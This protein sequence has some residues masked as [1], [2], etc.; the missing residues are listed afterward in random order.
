M[1][2]V[3]WTSRRA[4]VV[5]RVVD[6]LRS[7]QPRHMRSPSHSAMSHSQCPFRSHQYAGP[8]MRRNNCTPMFVSAF[9]LGDPLFPTSRQLRQVSRFLLPVCPRR[10]LPARRRQGGLCPRLCPLLVGVHVICSAQR[11]LNCAHSRIGN[12]SNKLVDDH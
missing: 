5:S 1:S 4:S 2:P 10:R 12:I 9:L 3:V 11:R 7:P 8:N 6:V